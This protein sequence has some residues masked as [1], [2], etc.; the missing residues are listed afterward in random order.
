MNNHTT[1]FNPRNNN[2][3]KESKYNTLQTRMKTHLHGKTRKYQLKMYY[4]HFVTEQQKG[5]QGSLHKRREPLEKK[6]KKM[7]YDHRSKNV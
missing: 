6:A 5:S 7:G 4:F 1:T 2:S 3:P